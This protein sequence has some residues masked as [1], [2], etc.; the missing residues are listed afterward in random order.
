MSKLR[1]KGLSKPKHITL[2]LSQR[3]GLTG[4]S[5]GG[6]GNYST[7]GNKRVI[8]SK[9]NFAQIVD[10]R[11]N[12][13]SRPCLLDPRMCDKYRRLYGYEKVVETE[14]IFEVNTDDIVSEESVDT[15]GIDLR[16]PLKTD[17]PKAI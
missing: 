2:G 10:L 13:S 16:T 15:V 5:T 12:K 17:W 8:A 4:C 3:F 9:C 6:G 7:T 14:R 1:I 11:W